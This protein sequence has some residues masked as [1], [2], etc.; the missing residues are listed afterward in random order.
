MAIQLNDERDGR[1]E[2]CPP[3]VYALNSRVERRVGDLNRCILR[4]KVIDDGDRC[5]RQQNDSKKESKNCC[6]NAEPGAFNRIEAS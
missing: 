2:R 1:E 6:E 5:A 4:L 3:T